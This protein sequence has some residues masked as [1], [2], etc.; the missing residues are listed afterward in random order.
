MEINVARSY[1]A[2]STKLET[3]DEFV[4]YWFSYMHYIS[5]RKSLNVKSKT[6]QEIQQDHSQEFVTVS[7]ALDFRSTATAGDAVTRSAGYALA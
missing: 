7:I 4:L 6:Y 3:G 5:S 1:C 2:R